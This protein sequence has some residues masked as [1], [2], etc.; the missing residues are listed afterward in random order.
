KWV[1]NP[2]QTK[3]IKEIAEAFLYEDTIQSLKNIMNVFGKKSF[4]FNEDDLRMS[5][6]MALKFE[7]PYEVLTVMDDMM[8]NM[9]MA[10]FLGFKKMIEFVKKGDYYN[11]AKE[12]KW[13]DGQK[14]DHF[15]LY[16]AQI[17]SIVRTL[18]DKGVENV[19]HRAEENIVLLVKAA[20]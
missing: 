16:Y 11:A 9:G 1:E 18:E 19:F 12:I 8:F 6:K 13:A 3:N 20:K 4:G 7:M 2:R 15:S 14:Q 10:R 17:D 5:N